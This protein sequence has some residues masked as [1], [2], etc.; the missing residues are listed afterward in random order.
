MFASL[1]AFSLT[2]GLPQ[3]AQADLV[4][5]DPGIPK[6]FWAGPRTIDVLGSNMLL[7]GFRAGGQ[8][9]RAKGP[10]KP[11]EAKG[12]RY[13]DSIEGITLPNLNSGDTEMWAGAF[14]TASASDEKA[15]VRFMPFLKILAY[16][17]ASGVATFDPGP[18][19]L[20]ADFFKGDDVL[21]CQESAVYSFKVVQASGNNAASIVLPPGLRLAKG[22]YILPAPMGKG[23]KLDYKYLRTLKMD[24]SPST[25]GNPSEWR[26]F[27]FAGDR[28]YSYTGSPHKEIFNP[29]GNYHVGSKWRELDFRD[30]VSPL[31]TAV[32]GV[33]IVKRTER[34][35]QA[36]DA[37]LYIATDSSYHIQ[38]EIGV[39][40]QVNGSGTFGNFTAC[41]SAKQSLWVGVNG[42]ESASPQSYT[43]SDVFGYVTITG[44]IEG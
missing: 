25:A 26:N 13:D 37:A 31:A 12:Y 18:G 5:S 14:A 43:D 36:G 38:V 41:F 4:V 19:T 44:W 35:A 7:N 6:V 27:A 28:T 11:F 24:Y 39:Y 22:D 15:G 29:L 1:I 10:M 32:I 20:T 9:T 21:I 30:Y 17:T 3:Q 23:G 2:L 34:S 8:Y 40:R 16:D 33:G 42:S